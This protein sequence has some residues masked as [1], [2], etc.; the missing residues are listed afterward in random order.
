VLT[1]PL[2]VTYNSTAKSLPRGSGSFNGPAK[3]LSQSFYATSDQEF[4]L[5]ITKLDLR[6][7]VR[8]EIIL[9]RNDVDA[10][11]NPYP[12]M[13][14]TFNGFGLILEANNLKLETNTDIPLLRT[15]LLALVDST[16]QAK[17]IGGEL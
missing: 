15:A 10:T 2:S 8:T 1:D 5:G 12:G 17:I 3:R 14:L 6:N 16:L 11:S 9:R 13:G 4:Q 7:A